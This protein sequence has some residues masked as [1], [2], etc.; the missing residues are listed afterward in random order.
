M[1]TD[2][3][4]KILI[5][6]VIILLVLNASIII[7]IIIHNYQLKQYSVQ[8]SYT[9]ESY[10]TGNMY[11]GRY[12][13]NQLNFN[14]HQID[15]FRLINQTFRHQSRKIAIQLFETRKKMYYSMISNKPNRLLLNNLAD[16]IGHLHSKLKRETYQFY[17]Q[18]KSICNKQQK[19]ILDSIFYNLLLNDKNFGGNG[20]GNK[21]GMRMQLHRKM[22]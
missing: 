5:W 4:F 15:S 22:Q 21:K 9:S 16:S 1:T 7:T 6:T 18:L 13:C 11:N 8:T 20:Q 12:F 3:K 17:F 2:K 19:E 14:D 10:P